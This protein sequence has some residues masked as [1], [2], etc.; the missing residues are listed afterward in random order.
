VAAGFEIAGDV[1][2]TY[3]GEGGI[4]KF[5]VRGTAGEGVCALPTLRE[6]TI[7]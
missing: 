3:R 1:T 7:K 6:G 5:G 4:A 2:A